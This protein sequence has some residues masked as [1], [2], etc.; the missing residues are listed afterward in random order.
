MLLK[1]L[2][3]VNFRN[4]T[5]LSL[6]FNNNINLIYGQNGQGKTSIL[7][8]I[9]TLAIT[10]SFKAKSEKVFLQN[11]KSHLDI[12]GELQN[13]NKDELSLRYFY[14]QNEGK[15]IFLN[16]NKVKKYSEI[17]GLAP[18]VLL[19][20]EDLDLMYGMPA[21]R[22]RFMDILLSQISA[23]YLVSL[24]CYKKALMQR[25]KLLTQINDGAGNQS[26]LDPW[27]I[28]V[29]QYGAEITFVRY[30]LAN[31]LKERLE[32]YYH[33][34]SDLDESIS[35]QYRSSIINDE[36]PTIEYLKS[37]FSGILEKKIDDD[38]RQGS[39]ITG[40]HRDDLLFLKDGYALKTHG[41]QGENKTL[42]IALK[43]AE[44]EYLM[45]KLKEQPIM[46]L[47]D[48]FGELDDTRI[49]HLINHIQKNGQSFITTTLRDKF[50]L[51]DMPD[52]HFIHMQNGAVLN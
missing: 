38:L 26:D 29:T 31:Y 21:H 1:H 32:G 7:E 27:T 16:G 3:L 5:E 2:N 10:R 51:R 30:Q 43:F 17:I 25:N 15:N 11:T 52:I 18:I 12:F 36:N 4:I 49:Q 20:L 45:N 33:F 22:R 40:P 46:L 44:R 39:T 41:S 8:A 34:I 6:E 37:E 35:I 9:F 24:Q 14:S 19:S 28:Q 42:L 23:S 50:E 13:S 47:D 48:V